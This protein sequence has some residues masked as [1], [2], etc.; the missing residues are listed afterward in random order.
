MSATAWQQVTPEQP[1]RGCSFQPGSSVLPGSSLM[2]GSSVLPDSSVLLGSSVL[3][4]SSA[5]D[6]GAIRLQA[7]DASV[8]D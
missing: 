8:R 3:P 4:G 5:H 2:L 7:S 1:G 6:N